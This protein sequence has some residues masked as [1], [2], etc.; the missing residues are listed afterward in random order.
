MVLLSGSRVSLKQCLFLCHEVN[1][2]I[3]PSPV[4]SHPAI[5]TLPHLQQNLADVQ[6]KVFH[7][8]TPQQVFALKVYLLS[9]QLVALNALV[10]DMEATVAPLERQAWT[11]RM[12]KLQEEV[13]ISYTS[14]KDLCDF[15]TDTID[16]DDKAS[17]GAEAS[18]ADTDIQSGNKE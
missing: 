4:K 13:N 1:A 16:S 9:Y 2:R 18:P 17:A 8:P 10:N 15:V 7:D 11:Q 5:P 14:A 3:V 12:Q 6:D